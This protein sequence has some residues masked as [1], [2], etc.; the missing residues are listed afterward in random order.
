MKQFLSLGRVGGSQTRGEVTRSRVS[1]VV[2]LALIGAFA[3][4]NTSRAQDLEDG[5]GD[6]IAE[7]APSDSSNQVLEIPQQCDPDSVA[8]LC[9]RSSDTSNDPADDVS[10]AGE[11][12][13]GSLYDYANQNIINDVSSTGTTNLP[14]GILMPGYVA[15]APAP[16]VVE[17]TGPGT[18]Q[19][20]AGGPGTYQQLGG[21]GTYPQFSPGP[22]Y[23]PPMPLGY[24]PYGPVY[25]PPSFGPHPFHSFGS[26]HFGRR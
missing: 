20:W 4:A 10:L 17:P 24:R 23:I 18:Y 22:G 12:D 19:Q 1:M 2:F 21:P 16:T 13:T 8:F 11:P 6:T 15:L 5:D 7:A 26:P 25:R 9:D 14:V 3:I